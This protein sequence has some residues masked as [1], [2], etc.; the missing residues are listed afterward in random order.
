MF[1]GSPLEQ[2]VLFF[3]HIQKKIETYSAVVHDSIPFYSYIP[4]PQKDDV[5]KVVML[6]YNSGK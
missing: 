6:P 3:S 5:A 4:F 1:E 2:E